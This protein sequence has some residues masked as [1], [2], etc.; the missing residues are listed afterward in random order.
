MDLTGKVA[1]VVG[2]SSGIGAAVARELLSRGAEVAI[3]ARRQDR[4][5]PA[6]P[7]RP[8]DNR[9]VE[10][11]VQDHQLEDALTAPEPFAVTGRA[12][13]LLPQLHV[14]PRLGWMTDFAQDA[15]RLRNLLTTVWAESSH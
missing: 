5:P 15:F 6:P 11:L 3:S 8:A 12:P 14:P 7:A 2:A 10:F 9:V 13:A 1:W 4:L